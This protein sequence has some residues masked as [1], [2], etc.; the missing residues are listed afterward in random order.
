M[1]TRDRRLP[2]LQPTRSLAP[3]PRGWWERRDPLR[4]GLRRSINAAMPDRSSGCV[5]PLLPSAG[6]STVTLT[7]PALNGLQG[8]AV[9]ADAIGATVGGGNT[10]IVLPA[11]APPAPSESGQ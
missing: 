7:A 4:R 9:E 3:A 1:R 2:A 10:L 5:R 6:W 8:I 11:V